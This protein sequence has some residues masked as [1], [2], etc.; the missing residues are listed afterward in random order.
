VLSANDKTN[1]K[2]AWSKVGGNSGAY[3]GEALYRTF[4]SFP[5]TKTYFPNYDFSAGSAQIKTQGQ[6]IADAVGLAVAHL[7]DM[8][9]ALSSLSDLHA[10]ELKVDPVNFKFLCHNVLVTMAAHLGKD[11]TPEIHASMDKFLASVSTVLTSKY[12]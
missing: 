12:R 9:T 6:K 4:L 1:V 10:H 8:P 11:F 7:D 5:T 2:G 3:M